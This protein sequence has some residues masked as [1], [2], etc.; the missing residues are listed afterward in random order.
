MGRT[1]LPTVQ[2]DILYPRAQNILLD[3]KKLEEEIFSS[4]TA[5]Q[6]EIVLGASSI[7]GDY[8]LPMAIASFS[9][10]NPQVTFD[11]RISDSARV[12]QAIV[13]NELLFG[14][15]G[16]IIPNKGIKFSP[17]THDELIL[18]A[19]GTSSFPQ[20][21]EAQDICSLPLLFREA[22][23]G[24]RTTLEKALR[25][26]AI[27]TDQLRVIAT[28]GSNTAIKEAVKAGYGLAF[29]S[30]LAVQD[31]LS[32]NSLRQIEVR[33]VRIE[34]EFYIVTATKRTLPIH[35]QSFMNQLL[36]AQ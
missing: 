18:V 17:F 19:A 24:T 26:A 28:L 30:R 15:T 6:G 27:L 31:E 23:S 14:I 29:L 12:V 11:I 34:R 1:I 21:L 36:P 13:E 35:Y 10:K 25:R 9:Q 4:G 20:H 32:C 5:I 33:D 7:P 3:M 22:G 2:A 8:I 16:S